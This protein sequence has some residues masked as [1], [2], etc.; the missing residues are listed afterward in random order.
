MI[1]MIAAV[2][3]NGVIGIDGTSIYSAAASAF[4]V[5]LPLKHF[6]IGRK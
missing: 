2:T 6:S 5:F 3:M 4:R 1:R